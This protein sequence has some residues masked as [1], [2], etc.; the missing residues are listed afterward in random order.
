MA[1]VTPGGSRGVKR[2][3]APLPLVAAIALAYASAVSNCATDD[4]IAIGRVPEL[5]PKGIA[6]TVITIATTMTTSTNVNP[7]WRTH[8]IVPDQADALT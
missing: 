3:V 7:R 5:M 4:R 1:I 8:R 6:A 2:S